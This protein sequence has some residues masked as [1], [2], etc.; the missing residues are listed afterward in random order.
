[1]S[2]EDET[3]KLDKKTL[4]FVANELMKRAQK[5]ANVLIDVETLQALDLTGA[6]KRLELLTR[7]ETCEALGKR[8]SEMASAL[9]DAVVPPRP[10][11]YMSQA[12]AM[13][14]GDATRSAGEVL[15]WILKEP[16]CR[17]LFV[18]EPNLDNVRETLSAGSRDPQNPR[19]IRVRQGYYKRNP[20]YKNQRK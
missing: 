2:K 11:D 12:C 20:K 1:M 14:L 15:H 3:Q 7:I 18:R 19:F 10:R 17:M 13:A 5:L 6:A 4:L 8:Y 16:A 9:P